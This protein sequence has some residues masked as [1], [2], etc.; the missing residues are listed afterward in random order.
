MKTNL[1]SLLHPQVMAILLVG[2]ILAAPSTS[3]NTDQ[4][5][6]NDTNEL[7]RVNSSEVSMSGANCKDDERVAVG[8]LP[9]CEPS[10]DNP[11]PICARIFVVMDKPACFCKEPLVRNKKSNL[12]VQLDQC[13]LNQL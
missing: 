4:W 10:C 8:M 2:T 5:H 12:C 1:L 6:F 3:D 9:G 11:K 7:L 13:E